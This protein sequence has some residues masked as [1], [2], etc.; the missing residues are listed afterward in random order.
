MSWAIP[1]PNTV[2]E[3]AICAACEQA[4]T[5]DRTPPGPIPRPWEWVH[6]SDQQK[7]CSPVNTVRIIDRLETE[8]G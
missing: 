2:R 6:I 3:Y 1:D 4:I 8:H 5:R 7:R